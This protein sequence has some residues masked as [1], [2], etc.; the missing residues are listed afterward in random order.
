MIKQLALVAA[1]AAIGFG[2]I[3][4]G[5]P[6]PTYHRQMTAVDFQNIDT[7]DLIKR[8]CDYSRSVQS[9]EWEESCKNAQDLTGINY[10]CRPQA[11]PQCWAEVQ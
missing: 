6:A 8:V 7:E 3:A 2:L 4:A 5:P 11:V 10:V 1:I 9:R